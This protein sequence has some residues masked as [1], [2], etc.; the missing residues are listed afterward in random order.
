VVGVVP[1]WQAQ[2]QSP[3]TIEQ[4]AEHWTEIVGTPQGVAEPPTS[5]AELDVV[6]KASAG[7]A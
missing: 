1:G 3:P 4:I 5:R 7:P 6:L 2:R